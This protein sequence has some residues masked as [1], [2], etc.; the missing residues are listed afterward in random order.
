[1][2]LIVPVVSSFPSEG[3]ARCRRMICP[4]WTTIARFAFARLSSSTMGPCAGTTA[5]VG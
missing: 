2:P 4:P 3:I 1:M 5:K